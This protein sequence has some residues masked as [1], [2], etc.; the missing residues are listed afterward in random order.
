MRIRLIGTGTMGCETRANTSIL[1]DDIL[2]D[3]GSGT[4]R[5]LV[6][7]DE[8]TNN[9]H[10]LVI[11]HFHADHFLDLPNL[12]IRRSIRKEIETKLVIIGPKGLRQKCIDLMLF[13]HSDNDPHKYDNL[14]QKYHIEFVELEKE[15]SYQTKTWKLLAKE[16]KHGECIPA[17]G[18]FLEKDNY[19]IVY[20]GDTTICDN[21]LA[22]C[23]QADYVFADNTSLTTK[24]AHIGI[25][26]YVNIAKQYPKTNFYAVHRADYDTSKYFGI[27][28][29]E[30][31]EIINL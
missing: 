23:Q 6:H 13:T 9:I 25:E 24:M 30:D 4:I 5:Q 27:H 8:K 19:K 16:V 17:Y 12:L 29:P 22:M 26:D 31:G 28:F 1:I 20:T 18:Y 15:Q 10:Y 11:S 3:I 2:F 7:L 21:V 14:E